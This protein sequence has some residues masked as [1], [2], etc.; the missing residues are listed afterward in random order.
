MYKD[1]QYTSVPDEVRDELRTGLERAVAAGMRRES[2]VLDPGLGFAKRAGH[3]FAALAALPAFA[4][5][6]RP[7]LVGPS[8]KSFLSA[9]VGERTPGER[10]MAT[11]GAVAAAALLGAH[12]VRV[13]NVTAMVDVIRVADAVRQAAFGESAVRL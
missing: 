10:D 11:A 8:R 3:T 13:H 12:I 2:V 7:L 4:A 9:A 6:G 5:L 1:A